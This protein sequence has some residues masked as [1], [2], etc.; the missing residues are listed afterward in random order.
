VATTYPYVD[1]VAYTD[2]T[3]GK[4][5]GAWQLDVM[6]PVTTA[7]DTVTA[8]GFTVD[9]QG[10]IVTLLPSAARTTDQTSAS[11]Y[12][13]GASGLAATLVV[14]AKTSSPSITFSIQAYDAASA[15]W[16]TLLTSAA[17]TG[18]STNTITVSPQIATSANVSLNRVIG[19]TVR[20]FVD[21]S[22]TDSITYSVG[23]DW[24]P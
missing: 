4:G 22:N 15:T 5:Q 1:G 17:I 8:N 12:G 2:A 20:I 11:L 6:S 3:S 21:H 23:L 9:D 18:A 13:R 10:R 24:T 19:D 16:I 14:T 7:A